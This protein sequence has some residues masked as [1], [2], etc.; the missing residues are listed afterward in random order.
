MSVSQKFVVN[1]LVGEKMTRN[2][3]KTAIR[4][5]RLGWLLLDSD[6]L[7]S[8]IVVFLISGPSIFLVNH[9]LQWIPKFNAH[10]DHLRN[11]CE[12][13]PN[14]APWVVYIRNLA[15]KNP[16]AI[17]DDYCIQKK[18]RKNPIKP[19]ETSCPTK[20]EPTKYTPRP[21]CT[22]GT[23]PTKIVDPLPDYGMTTL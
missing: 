12:A 22:D 23:M 21:K 7:I 6:P 2:G 20:C 3:Q 14:Q 13:T 9:F 17:T 1:T 10:G 11:G 19:T 15:Y 8:S 4:A 18:Y 16:Y 5:G